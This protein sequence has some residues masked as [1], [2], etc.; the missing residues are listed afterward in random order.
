M[1]H[2]TLNDAGKLKQPEDTKQALVVDARGFRPE[3][4]DPL[5]V[6]S[7]FLDHTHRM[8]WRRFII[9]RVEGQRGIGMGMGSGD[10]S[11]TNLD[12]YGSPGEYCGAFN[13]GALVRVHGHAQNFTGMVMHS[14]TLEIHG[15][16]GKVTGY[17]AKG[18]TF[19]ILG[20]VVDRGWV[21][22]VSDPR[23]PGLQVNIVG[24]AYEHICQAFM[25]GSVIM[26]GLYWGTDGILHRMDSPYK[27]GKILA[28]ASA[29]EIVFY[30]P[31]GRLDEAQY[32]SCLVQAIDQ[33]K[34]EEIVNRLMNLE[35]IFGLGISREN[36][37]LTAMIAGHLQTLTPES[38]RWILPKGELEGY[39]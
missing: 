37:H 28:G 18:G 36:N 22:A 15:D 1:Y 16:V 12:V 33:K 11:D 31:M 26:L 17:S 35:R 14:G 38:F 27:G 21:C 39:H 7:C 5:N 19:N 25:G 20:N 13:M 6:L 3:G 23:G 24:T 8:G 4:V 30:D 10:T 29:G 34:W 9:H 32:K 2:V